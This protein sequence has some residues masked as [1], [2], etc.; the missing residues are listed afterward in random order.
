MVQ[1]TDSGVRLPGFIS[2]LSHKLR[3]PC[4]RF[5]H[6]NGDNYDFYSTEV[7]GGFGESV[8]KYLQQG[9]Q[10]AFHKCWLLLSTS[11]RAPYLRLFELECR[12]SIMVICC[13]GVEGP[14]SIL[15]TSF[16]GH[17]GPWYPGQSLPSRNASR[18]WATVCSLSVLREERWG[19]LLSEGGA[20]GTLEL[21]FLLGE[22][23]DLMEAN[24]Q[25]GG[26]P[27]WCAGR[28]AQGKSRSHHALTGQP[29][30]GAHGAAESTCCGGKREKGGGERHFRKISPAMS[31]QDKLR[32]DS[33]SENQTSGL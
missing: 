26:S 16:S 15:T 1:S 11:C 3:A 20:A 31:S 30:V 4:L 12:I 10:G 23:D 22:E 17:F 33:H 18:G 29:R 7:W 28:W 21:R 14:P 13:N 2:G 9:E 19:L 25:Q 27:S 24:R 8:T 32:E 5:P 6:I